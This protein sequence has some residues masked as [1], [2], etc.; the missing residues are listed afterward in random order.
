MAMK[1]AA[2][3]ERSEHAVH[4]HP[5]L[6]LRR[7]QEVR[8]DHGEHEQVVD[9]EAPLDQV[10]REVLAGGGAALR[11]RQ[12]DR[13]RQAERDPAD[14]PD[15][16]LLDGDPLVAPPEEEEVDCGQ[17]RD[18][19]D[20]RDPCPE[21]W[22]HEEH[23]PSTRRQCAE[24]LPR[25]PRS[26]RP[27]C[28]TGPRCGR[29]DDDAVPGVLPYGRRGWY[30]PDLSPLSSADNPAGQAAPLYTGAATALRAV[31]PAGICGLSPGGGASARRLRT[32]R[33][34]ARPP[35]PGPPRG[36]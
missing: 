34:S 33:T 36:T 22:F 16:G 26:A 5:R 2:E 17:H 8:E 14:A 30:P 29:T 24:G 1:I 10:T 18:A 7:D 27:A 13:E 11:E 28:V 21:R 20:E 9:R 35:P 19:Q 3:H 31:G 15:R 4:Q 12:D 25:P 32:S 6:E 23:S